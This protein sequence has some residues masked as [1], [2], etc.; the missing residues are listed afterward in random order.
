MARS[1][2]NVADLSGP[3]GKKKGLMKLLKAL[4][5]AGMV[6]ALLLTLSSYSHVEYSDADILGG[7]FI[8]A[9][10]FSIIIIRLWFS[11]PSSSDRAHHHQQLGCA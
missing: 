8:L 7:Y 6:T 1:A 10:W 4:W 5:A 11:V 2:H 3:V 9:L